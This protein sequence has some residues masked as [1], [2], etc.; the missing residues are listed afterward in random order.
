MEDEL[1]KAL[2]ANDI[3]EARSIMAEWAERVRAASGGEEAMLLADALV[4]LS[5]H[6][7]GRLRQSVAQAADVF[8]ESAF[9]HALATFTKDHDVYV[10]RAIER[11]AKLRALQRK[12]RAKE[13]SHE[14]VVA[15][16]L[17]EIESRH[18]KPARRLAERAVRRGT[19]YFVRKLHHEASKIAT[20]LE[21]AITRLRAE[22]TRPY[23][24]PAAIAENVRL[25]AASQRHLQ[26]IL[27]R[28]REATVTVTPRFVDESLLTLVQEARAHLVTRLGLR[29]ECLAFETDIPYSLR[30]DV[31]R[32]AFLQALQNFFQN[33]VEAY[34]PAATRLALVVTARSLR[35][36]SQVEITIADRG[37]GMSEEQQARLFVPFGTGKA[38]GTGL[39]LVIARTMIDEIHNGT[40]TLESAVG[41]GTT[42]RIVLPTQQAGYRKRQ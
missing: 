12:A 2:S 32:S 18:G 7:D 27:D 3:A 30:F 31:D 6:A 26:T 22:I 33:A 42:V 41:V 36:G 25:A 8:P 29:S 9:E 4:P 17:A 23:P 10:Q 15:D 40:V 39:G 13:A 21:V 11:A 5:S 35:A 1:R 38:G 16:L 37:A 28:A 34:P 14:K 20:P 19:E 24:R